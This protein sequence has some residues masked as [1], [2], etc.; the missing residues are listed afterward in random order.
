LQTLP[1]FVRV[2]SLIFFDRI[3]TRYIRVNAAASGQNREKRS[4]LKRNGVDGIDKNITRPFFDRINRIN[5][6]K[7]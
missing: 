1:D 5:W 7:K 4:A 3:I 6:I 2:Q